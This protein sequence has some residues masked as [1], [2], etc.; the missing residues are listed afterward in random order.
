MG[1]RLVFEIAA[2]DDRWAVTL[3]DINRILG[4]GYLDPWAAARWSRVASRDRVRIV[5]MNG[6]MM[7]SGHCSPFQP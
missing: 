7:G 1:G 4:I 5:V 2:S 3:R 6:R